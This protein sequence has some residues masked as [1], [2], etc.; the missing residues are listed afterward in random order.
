MQQSAVRPRSLPRAFGALA[1]CLAAG[2]SVTGCSFN[3]SGTVNPDELLPFRD[4]APFSQPTTQERSLVYEEPGVFA[5]FHGKT[6]SASNHPTTQV[7]LRVQ[8]ELALPKNLDRGTVLLNGF[9]LFYLYEDHHVKGLGTA[10]GAIEISNGVLRWEAGGVL[11]DN[12]FNDGYGWCYFYTAVAWNSQELQVSVSH[13]DTGHA[14]TNR[15]VTDGTAL[16]P[17]PGYLYH[18]SW[19]ADEVAVVPRGF[20]YILTEEDHHLLQ[21]AFEHDAGEVYVEKDKT[22]TAHPPSPPRRSGPATSRGKARDSSRTTRRGARSTSS[23]W[24]PAWAGTTSASSRLRSAC[25][26][27][28]TKGA[29]VGASAATAT[30]PTARF[31]PYLSN[32]PSRC[33]AAGIS[34]TTATTSTWPTSAPG[35]SKWSWE[36]GTLAAGGT[37]SYILETRL[38]DKDGL[39]GF[40]DRT[41]VKI[42]G[43]RRITP[44]PPR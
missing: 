23:I 28:R 10:I 16:N 20:A 3:P 42:L 24:S 44:V 17:I 4:E 38:N 37:L 30:R 13:G 31:L 11:S 40:Y 5:A 41:Q 34:P 19:D 21:I 33:S 1:F 12:D 14:F 2:L 25:C 26:R 7:A 6:C 18:P 29:A 35:I 36:P 27:A 8:E 9:H 32:L 43:F 22:A 39:P 15:F